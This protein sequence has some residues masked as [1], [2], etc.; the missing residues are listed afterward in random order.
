MGMTVG[1]HTDLLKGSLQS[2]PGIKNAL[3]VAN[4]I[5]IA[6]ELHSMGELSDENY[7]KSLNNF[8]KHSGFGHV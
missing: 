4:A 7:I 5:A 1:E 2:I 3:D 8:L 6:K